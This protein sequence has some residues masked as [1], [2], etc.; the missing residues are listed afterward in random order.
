MKQ[1]LLDFLQTGF[2]KAEDLNCAEKI[3]WGANL[4]YGLGITDDDLRLASGFG[5][6]MGI[7][8]LCGA[9]AGAVMVLSRMFVKE[10]AHEGTRIKELTG[11]FLKRFS[12]R[13]G[14]LDCEPIKEKHRSPE[15]G[16]DFV[17]FTSAEILDDIVKR[18]MD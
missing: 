11:E 12:E 14:S 8:A 16:C 2:G 13:M 1:T 7:G 9:A 17:I 10:R 5:G 18:E 3:L 4:V 6:G 15:T